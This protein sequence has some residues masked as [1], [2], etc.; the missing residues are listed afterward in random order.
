MASLRLDW[1]KI[2]AV[3][4]G[5]SLTRPALSCTA[6]NYAHTIETALRELRHLGGSADLYDA[7]VGVINQGAA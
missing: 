3:A 6:N 1:P 4:Q 2:A 5:F 7:F